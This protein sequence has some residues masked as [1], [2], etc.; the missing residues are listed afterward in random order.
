MGRDRY[1]DFAE[2]EQRERVDRDWR[3]QVAV[4]GSAVVI[5]APHG[6]SI[7]PGTSEIAREIAG[8]DLSL[9]CFEG[10]RARDNDRLHIT[11]TRFDEPIC[12]QLLALSRIAV[13]IHGC[14][15]RE[16]IVYLGGRHRELRARVERALGDAGFAAREDTGRHSGEDPANICNRAAAAMGLQL[17]ISQGLRRALFPGVQR[18]EWR[19]A[20]P[21]FALFASAV[22][23]ALRDAPPD[24]LAAG[25]A[26]IPETQRRGNTPEA[27]PA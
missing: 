16:P 4:R 7:E 20:D 19:Q 5:L 2:L 12:L 25:P 18:H 6:G 22:R 27:P 23:L 11:S 13:T 21:A 9:Y 17:E 15:D 14:A 1:R 3:V 10:I 24:G 8:R 26:G